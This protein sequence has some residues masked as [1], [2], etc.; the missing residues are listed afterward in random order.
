MKNGIIAKLILKHFIPFFNDKS[1]N[2]VENTQNFRLRHK[3]IE[4]RS[5]TNFNLAYF[6]VK[7]APKAR[8]IL[9]FKKGDNPPKP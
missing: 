4:K 8:N 2:V 3:F 7:I 1:L 6:I 5:Q 9:G